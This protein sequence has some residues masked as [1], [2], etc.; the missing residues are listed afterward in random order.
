MN[1]V[2]RATMYVLSALHFAAIGAF[3]IGQLESFA[4]ETLA[5]VALVLAILALAF[6]I[7]SAANDMGYTLPWQGGAAE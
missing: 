3:G 6:A 1:D 7:K 4:R 2:D 5:P